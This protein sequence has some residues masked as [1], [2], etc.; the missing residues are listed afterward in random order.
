MKRTHGLLGVVLAV[1]VALGLLSSR[2]LSAQ[3]PLKSGTVIH[4]TD[5]VSAKGMEAILVLRE[6]PP[7]AAS[8]K[9]TQSSNEVVYIL[10]GSVILEVQG[11]PPVTVKAGEAFS[12]AAGQVH[13]VKNASSSAPT[14]ALAFY[15]AKKG[16]ALEGL[17]V[18][19][20]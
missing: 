17:S 19:A 14:K 8:G 16:T 11:K 7:G 6:V 5:L 3:D 1:G 13:N 18:P 4:R 10:E 9:H 12:T 15:I 2:M 20:K